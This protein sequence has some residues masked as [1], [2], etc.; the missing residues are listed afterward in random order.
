MFREK[1]ITFEYEA[2]PDAKEILH[3]FKEKG[4]ENYVISNNFPELGKAFERLGLIRKYQDTSSVQVSDMKNREKKYLNTQWNK[5]AT[6][7]CVT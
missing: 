4:F 2:Y 1:V 3:Y 5:R 7:R 6:Q